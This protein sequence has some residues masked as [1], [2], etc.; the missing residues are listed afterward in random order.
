MTHASAHSNA[1]KASLNLVQLVIV[2]V[3]VVEQLL[4]FFREL[5]TGD[6]SCCAAT[7][8]E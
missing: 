7:I 4:L 1:L 6:W 5:D 2:Q 8:A 3:I